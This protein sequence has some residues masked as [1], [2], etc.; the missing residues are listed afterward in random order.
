MKRIVARVKDTADSKPKRNDVVNLKLF[1]TIFS[2][3]C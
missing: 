2:E 1:V 3:G